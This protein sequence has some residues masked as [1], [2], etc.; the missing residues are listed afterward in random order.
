MG[1]FLKINQSYVQRDVTKRRPFANFYFLDMN[2]I[3]YG[4]I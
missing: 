1:C 2:I 3:F 4:H